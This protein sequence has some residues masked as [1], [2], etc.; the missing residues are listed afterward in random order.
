MKVRF[1]ALILTL[2]VL[3]YLVLHDAIR[4]ETCFLFV[5]SVAVDLRMGD[6]D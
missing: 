2:M 1:G 4:K 3:H 6:L 5:A